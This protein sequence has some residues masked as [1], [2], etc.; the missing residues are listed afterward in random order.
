MGVTENKLVKATHSRHTKSGQRSRFPLVLMSNER[1]PADKQSAEGSMPAY[2]NEN[3]PYAAQWLR[4][5]I[6]AGQIAPG[7][8]DERSIQDV[9]ADDLRGYTQA[10]FFAGIGGW[11]A[12]L[13]SQD[14]QTAE[15]GQALAPAS[16]SPQPE[17][18]RR[19]MT[20]ATCGLRGFLSSA[21]AALQSSLESRLRRQL[22]GAGSMLFSL[23]WKRKGTPA[24]RPYYQ[25]AAS[26]R[27][28]SDN[29][30]GSWPS[31]CA[32]QANGEP[33]AFLERKRRSVERG[34]SMGISL[35][36]LQMVAKLASWPTPT[37]HD[38]ERGGQEKRATTERHGSNLQDFALTAQLAS[39]PTPCQQDG[40]KGGPSQGIDRLPGAASLASWPTTTVADSWSPSTQESIDHEVSKNN[41]RGIVHLAS[42][43]MPTSRDWKD[44]AANLD[45]VPV[46]GLLGRQAL[47]SPA[48]TERRGQLNPDFS[49]WLM[50]YSAEHLSCA[51]T[52]MLSSHKSQRS[53]SP[54]RQKS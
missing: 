22:D 16:P 12:A 20:N 53:S 8:V 14:G 27:R 47:L 24:G 11:S 28:T 25:L 51:P 18:A 3:D 31:P 2:Y 34:N 44:G 4:N 46:N 49:R 35:T 6:A 19:P 33:E 15:S 1:Q 29:D 48:Q 37:L 43:A 32:Q 5:L 54:L 41:L 23:T 39:W 26:A 45:N 40:P 30:C 21:S 7:D 13:R 50:G 52:A 42:W 38:A 10:H 9:S 36:D 17:R